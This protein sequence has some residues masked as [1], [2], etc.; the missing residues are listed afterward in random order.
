VGAESAKLPN[1]RECHLSKGEVM[2][3]FQQG[4]LRRKS[5]KSGDIWVFCYRR[6]RPKDGTWIEATGIT[7]GA[8]KD[9]P[10][11]EAAWRRVKELHL[12]PNQSPIAV[13]ARILF[14]ELTA[15][16]M[17]RELPD[18]QSEATIEKAYSTI[19]KY[20]RYLNRWALP[21]WK[22]TPALALRPP[23]VEDWLKDLKKKSALSN[24]SLGEIRKAMNNVYVHGQRQG[25]LPRTQD[26]NP[27]N[28]VRQSLASDFEPVILTLPQV[29]DIFDNL[30][31]MRRTMVLT[32]AATAL[33]V[34]EVLALQ[35]KDLDF[36]AQLIRVRR[37]YVERRF[38][39]PKSKASKAP[40]PMHPLLAAHLLA[41]RKETLYPADEDLVFPSL[42]LKGKKPPAAN[43]LVSDYLRVA[44][45]K[46]GV[47]AAP[48][49]FGF[50][51]FRRTLASVLV[52]MKVN[53][54]TVQ[55]ILRHQ[56][57]KTTLEIYA[58][59]MTEDKLQAQ[60]MFLEELFSQERKNP[61]QAAISTKDL[62][63]IE[64]VVRSLQ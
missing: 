28:F 60:G 15:N 59:A 51:T 63:N 16:Y 2:A 61:P 14:G 34:S 8:I 47:I 48:R 7:V 10:S 46:A 64:P 1:S 53:V 9:Y 57:L 27:I 35:W 5:R 37:A 24:P 39:K 56:N 41:W 23:D 6:R 54:K 29:L 45:E 32:D 38:G 43:M 31:L 44:A 19:Y 55:E 25:L 62:E 20:K 36:E 42:R 12:N 13:G 50:H 17:Q 58:K 40:V 26:G 21:R 18:D 22:N 30:D 33:R 4:W 11:E 3:R 49:T 52:R